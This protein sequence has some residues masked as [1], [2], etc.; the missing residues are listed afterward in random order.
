MDGDPLELAHHGEPFTLAKGQ[1]MTHAIPPAPARP[2]PV[3]PPGREPAR[4]GV[5]PG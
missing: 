4:R 1:P 3:Q 5:E 2:T